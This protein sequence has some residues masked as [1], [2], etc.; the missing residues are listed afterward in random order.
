MS[1]W[2]RCT[3]PLPARPLL[4]PRRPSSV[5]GA[6]GGRR[7]PPPLTVEHGHPRHRACVAHAVIPRRAR[8]L[9]LVVLHEAHRVGQHRVAEG[10][11]PHCIRPSGDRGGGARGA[12]AREKGEGSISARGQNTGGRERPVEGFRRTHRRW[13]DGRRW[14][15]TS[16]AGSPQTPRAAGSR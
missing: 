11:E 3:T 16:L 9:G 10:V 2:R 6:S 14:C 7:A 8:L 5:R 12:R 15:W 4:S 13:G 1:A